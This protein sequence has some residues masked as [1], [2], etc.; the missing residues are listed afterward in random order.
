MLSG[1]YD[2]GLCWDLIGF[3]QSVL[4]YSDKGLNLYLEKSDDR[5]NLVM[6]IDGRPIM[7]TKK[8]EYELM[9]AAVSE[10]PVSAR[11]LIGG[12]GFGLVLLYLAES[13]KA[14]E[15]ICYER[16]SRVLRK[17]LNPVTKFLS[18]HY[19]GFNF[20]IIKGDVWAKVKTT[21][22]YDWIFVDLNEGN[23]AGFEQLALKSLSDKGV[24]TRVGNR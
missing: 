3:G 16:D 13:G 1:L 12:L 9:M 14:R 21:G 5:V 8:I 17:F 22:K 2:S 24:F 15:V 10:C 19:P 20:K 6:Y 23:P 4:I 7:S 11:V 18:G